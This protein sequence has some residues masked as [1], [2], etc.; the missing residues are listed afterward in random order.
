M[1]SV[2]PS[3]EYLI[4]Q[5]LQKGRRYLA[6]VENAGEIRQ[7]GHNLAELQEPSNTVFSLIGVNLLAFILRELQV[8]EHRIGCKR[9]AFAII[10]SK[11][12]YGQSAPVFTH[13]LNALEMLANST[14]LVRGI[15]KFWQSI[16]GRA[17]REAACAWE[18]SG[19][20]YRVQAV[21]HCHAIW[22]K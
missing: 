3:V 11:S 9:L 17:S 20:F 8:S 6:A 2:A 10:R 22:V 4:S 13:I 5:D 7:S 12:I 18:R 1:V 15:D 14:E 19:T 21:F 16:G